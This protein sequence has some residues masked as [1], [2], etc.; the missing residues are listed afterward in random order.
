MTW[1]TPG[2]RGRWLRVGSHTVNHI[3]FAKPRSNQ[4]YES[5]ESLAAL[6][7]ELGAR[8]RAFAFSLGQAPK[9]VGASCRILRDAGYYAITSAYVV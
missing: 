2:H 7:R 6:D 3:D 9:H 4:E 5:R 8:P 1:T